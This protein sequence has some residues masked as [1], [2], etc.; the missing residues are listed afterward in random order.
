MREWT[1]WEQRA[2]PPR[3]APMGFLAGKDAFAPSRK[4]C[5][6]EKQ[7]LRGGVA[8]ALVLAVWR[9]RRAVIRVIIVPR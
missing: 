6:V 5:D 7:E 1:S 9:R 8:D 4:L 2:Y 3:N